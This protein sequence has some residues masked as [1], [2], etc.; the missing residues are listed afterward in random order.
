M[1]ITGSVSNLVIVNSPKN[2]IAIEAPGKTTLSGITVDNSLGASHGGH[3]T[4]GINIVGNTNDL[5]VT[6]CTVTNQDDCIS[7]T[8]GKG[9]TLSDNVCLM[10][11]GISIGSMKTGGHVS[12]VTISGNRVENSQQ[13][14]RIKTYSGATDASVTNIN[15]IGNTGKNLHKY[16]V[17]VQQGESSP[18]E[19]ATNGV[20]IS[21]VRFTGS[22]TTL[23]VDSDA[24]EVYVLCGTNSCI[25]DWNWGSLHVSGGQKGSITNAP[26][27]GWP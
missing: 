4:D 13:G 16:G 27:R 20:K 12:D 5:T 21:N 8:S 14:Y 22:P 10:G 23:S 6:K 11:H 26:I 7:V 15:F 19:G 24:Q 3:N 17:V 25:G 18:L 9:V 2:A 1:Y